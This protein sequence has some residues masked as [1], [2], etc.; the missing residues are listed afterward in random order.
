VY[1]FGGDGQSRRD[2]SV[3]IGR[4]PAVSQIWRGT[5]SS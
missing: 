1:F 3:H 5:L 2:I 4:E